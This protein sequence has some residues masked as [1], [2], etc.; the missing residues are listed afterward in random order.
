MLGQRHA[1]AAAFE[2]RHTEFAFE[3]LHLM[4]DGTMG[5]VQFDG[6]SAEVEVTR[7]GLEGAQ[8]MQRRQA[9]GH[10]M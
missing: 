2:Q 3:R 8:E 1:P 6:G 5:D 9:D 10:P 4:A 7:G